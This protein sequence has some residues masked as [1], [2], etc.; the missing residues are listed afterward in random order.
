MRSLVNLLTREQTTPFGHKL[1]DPRP[2][3]GNITFSHLG[4]EF[5]FDLEDVSGAACRGGSVGLVNHR[6]KKITANEQLALAA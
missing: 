1:L 5:G 2:G 6:I 4:G 3:F